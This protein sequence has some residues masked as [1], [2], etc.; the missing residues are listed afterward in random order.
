[1]AY[2]WNVVEDDT[3]KKI[4]N[5]FSQLHDLSLFPP[6]LTKIE[7]R[8]PR[9]Y[10]KAD[11]YRVTNYAGV[12]GP[13]FKFAAVGDDFFLLDGTAMPI[14]EVNKRDELSLTEEHVIAYLAYFLRNVQGEHGEL[15]IVINNEKS[16]FITQVSPEERD[17][18]LERDHNMTVSFSENE[19]TYIAAGTLYYE[20]DLMPATFRVSKN[21]TV[22]IDCQSKPVVFKK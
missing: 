10:N 22:K 2:I 11:H 16:R 8:R 3:R 18:I 1:M 9:F 21:G 17:R 14:Y 13:S 7:R 4:F 12:D 5:R 6:E 20:E 19:Q 15:D